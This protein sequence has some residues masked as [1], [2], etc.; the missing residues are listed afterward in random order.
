MEAETEV[1]QPQAKGC[2]EFLGPLEGRRSEEE[3]FSRAF[4]GS[5]ALPTP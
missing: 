2:Q 1:M 4:R 5:M 3:L